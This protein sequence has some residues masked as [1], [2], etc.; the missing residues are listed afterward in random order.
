MPP[1][2]NLAFKERIGFS[3]FVSIGASLVRRCLMIAEKRGFNHI[4][5]IVM[6]KNRNMLA[7]AKKLGFVVKIQEDPGKYEVQIN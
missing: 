5:G 4:H 3:N 2:G 6:K 1:A 7:L